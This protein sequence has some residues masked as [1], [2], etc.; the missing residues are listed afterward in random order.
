MEYLL[1]IIIG[2]LVGSLP[3]A[4]LIL[5]ISNGVDIR[6]LGSKNVGTLNS[7]DVTK[8]K[9]IAGI[10][11][12]VDLI[13]GIAAAFIPKLFFGDFFI[14]SMLS[15][16]SAVFSHCYSPWIKFK[17]GRGLATAA[18]GALILS[19]PVFVVWIVFWLISFLFRKN[20][21]FSNFTATLLTA[22][23]SITSGDILNKYSQ[24]PSESPRTF[25]ILVVLMMLI[26]LSRHIQPMKEYLLTEK[27]K[28]KVSI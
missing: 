4:Y 24:P 3:T 17:G 11:L 18:G 7:Y 23:I 21:H 16:A 26:I 15:L 28:R 1:S 14:F 12:I 22:A 5:K 20:I 25:T 8:S 6:E 27:Q 10:V 13:K 9:T 19:I 2:Y